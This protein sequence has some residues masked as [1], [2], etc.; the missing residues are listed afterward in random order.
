MT[1]LTKI[2]RKKNRKATLNRRKARIQRRAIES[3]NHRVR[4]F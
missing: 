2:G 4:P 1:P 3:N